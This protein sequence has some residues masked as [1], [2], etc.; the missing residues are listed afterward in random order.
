MLDAE[1]TLRWLTERPIAHRG[2]H[3]DNQGI[4]ENSLSAFRAAADAGYAIECDV[5]LSADGVPMVF[6]D[7][8]LDRLT[9][10]SGPVDSLTAAELETLRIGRTQD[11]IPTFR[12]LLDLVGGRVPIVAELKG[13]SAESDKG[14]A[15]ALEPIVAAYAGTLALMSFDDWLIE[16]AASMG[17]RLPIGLT[18]EGTRSETIQR[19]RD[20]FERHCSF[21]SYN[22]HHL[23]NPFT[24]WLREEK[25]LPVISWTVRS[26]EDRERSG[27]H[28]DQM[29]FEGFRP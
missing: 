20:L 22:V 9:E 11:T 24:Q 18:A 27:R 13:R 1:P 15:A 8:D 5:R 21:A 28:A 29:T 12:S 25:R 2:L 23:P 17:H 10:R 26:S 6:H 14:F 19:H 3:D 4:C 7:D 16:A